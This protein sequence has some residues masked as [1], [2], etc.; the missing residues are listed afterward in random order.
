MFYSKTTKGFYDPTIHGANIPPD[1]VEITDQQ[2]A[3]LLNGQSAGKVITADANGNP[4]LTDPPAPTADQLAASA[5]QKRD[6]LITAIQWRLSRY[7]NQVAQGIAPNDTADQYK[8]V[9]V[10]V[11]ALRDLT[12]QAGFPATI[13]WPTISA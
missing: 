12:K 8:A 7:E 9:L 5:R 4:E 11:Q 2:H 10:Y 6:G 13:T 1:A 3:D